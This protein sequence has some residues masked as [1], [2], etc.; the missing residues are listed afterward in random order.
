MKDADIKEIL[1]MVAEEQITR[2][3]TTC[4]EHHQLFTSCNS[5]HYASAASHRPSFHLWM[6]SCSLAP[7]LSYRAEPNSCAAWAYYHHTT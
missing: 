2:R 1:W 5:P 4:I 6:V 3:G 7:Q